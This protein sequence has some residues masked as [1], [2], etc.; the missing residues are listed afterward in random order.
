MSGSVFEIT[1]AVYLG[2]TPWHATLPG[3][4]AFRALQTAGPTEIPYHLDVSICVGLKEIVEIYQKTRL[5]TATGKDKGNILT[6]PVAQF[7]SL[8]NQGI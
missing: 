4:D 3:L 1:S 5:G 8:G 7:V 2:P 6:I